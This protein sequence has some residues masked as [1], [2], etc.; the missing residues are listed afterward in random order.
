MKNPTGTFTRR[1][2]LRLGAI[3]LAAAA[4]GLAH[5][6]EPNFPTKPISIVV[7]FAAGGSLDVTARV[8]AERMRDE[9]GQQVLIQNRPGA[10]STIGARSV[11]SAAPDGYT[12][13]LASGSAFGFAHLLV[14]GFDLQLSNFEPIAGLANNTSVFAVNSSVP[15][16]SLQDLVA[17]EQAKP[18]S[19]NFCTTGANGLNHLQLLMFKSELKAKGINF[20]AAHV[21][22]NGVAPAITALRG[23]EVQ[24]CTL[25]YSGMIKQMDGKEIRV[26]AVQRPKRLPTLPNVPTTG[27]Q[28]YVALDGNDALVNLSAPKG[29]P[30]AIIKRLETAV[31]AAMKDPAI[32]KR[33]EEIDVQPTYVGAAETKKWLEADVAKFSKLI[34]ES[35]LTPD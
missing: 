27:E 34:K 11:A 25:P 35:G 22:Y 24:A 28:G 18:G 17:M 19:V 16:K 4:A 31:Q 30:P 32:V 1:T 7:P 29:T 14:R 20:A 2:A 8:L 12:L 10:G 13:F 3:G 5:A 33:L 15:A 6:A 23:G 9:L 21:P 26:L